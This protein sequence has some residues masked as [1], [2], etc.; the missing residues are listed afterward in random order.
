MI[1]K[2]ILQALKDIYEEME[3]DCTNWSQLKILYK[4]VLKELESIE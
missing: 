4:A 3:Y 1:D 2:V